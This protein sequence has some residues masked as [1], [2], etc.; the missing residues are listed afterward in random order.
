MYTCHSSLAYPSSI[1]SG[2]SAYLLGFVCVLQCVAVCCSAFIVLLQ[3]VCRALLRT[4]WV[5]SVCCSVLQWVAVG[6]SMLQYVAV[7]CSMLQYVAVCCSLLQYV[8]VCCSMLIVL[9]Q[10]VCRAPLRTSWALSV[11]VCMCMCV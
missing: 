8:A 2:S 6:C 1:L 5:L 4:S 10:C 3:C 7:C 9:L 11:F